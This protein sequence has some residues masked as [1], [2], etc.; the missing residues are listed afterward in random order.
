MRAIDVANALIAD[1]GAVGF[2][3]NMKL[4]KLVYFA[5]ADDLARGVPSFEAAFEAWQY[6]PVE[7]TV[8]HAFKS[9]GSSRILS[10]S[11]TNVPK[12]AH[13]VAARVWNKFG[14]LTAIDLMK[15]S[16]RDG[17]A[18]AACYTG[19]SDGARITDHAIRKSGDG[20]LSEPSGSFSQAI[21][22]A[23]ARW[24]NVLDRLS[25]S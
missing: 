25:N 22:A 18:W 4:N 23:S 2:I 13:E 16:H 14:E 1:Y 12:G 8:Y 5:Y 3:T 9:N 10:P 17:G 21:D 11:D 7:P 20:L 6:G 24:S 15:L 19:H